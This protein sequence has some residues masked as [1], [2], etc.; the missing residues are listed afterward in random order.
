MTTVD[1]IAQAI[2]ENKS[3]EFAY[4][5]FDRVVSPYACGLT[6][7]NEIKMV[8]FQTSGGS[9]SGI[10]EKLRF[11]TV[12]DIAGIAVSDAPFRPSTEEDKAIFCQLSKVYEEVH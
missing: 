11:Y 12:A 1:T 4:H 8:G 3:L 10:T 2:K 9:N 6:P 5:G 7:T